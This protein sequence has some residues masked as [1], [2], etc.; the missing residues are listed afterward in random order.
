MKY[1]QRRRRG[2]TDETS[3]TV[4]RAISLHYAHV[5]KQRDNG[6]KVIHAPLGKLS[7]SFMYKLPSLQCFGFPL[8]TSSPSL[9]DG[10]CS[11]RCQALQCFDP[12]QKFQTTLCLLFRPR[13]AHIPHAH[14][15]K[16]SLL[17][18]SS[19]AGSGTP[20]VLRG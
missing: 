8:S 13:L 11:A 19:F 4:R 10:L 1:H 16:L 3:H 9:D 12:F 20:T 15:L 18:S 6:E 5:R 2:I 17:L 14:S 7:N